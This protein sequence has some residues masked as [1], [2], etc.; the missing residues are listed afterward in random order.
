MT[1]SDT[2][3]AGPTTPPSQIPP[4]R[5][6]ELA[7]IVIYGLLLALVLPEHEPWTDEAQSWL[8][9]RDSS[10][11]GLLTERLRYEGTP[12]LWTLLL[13]VPAKLGLPYESMQVIGALG[14][15]GAVILLV[16]FSP[17][18]LWLR[19]LLPFTYFLGYQYALVARNYCLLALLLFALVLA[20]R[21]RAQR[22]GPFAWCLGLLSH[23]TLHST[24]LAGAIWLVETA[25]ALSLARRDG[26]A[27]ARPRLTALF[28]L[29]LNFVLVL[30]IIWPPADLLLRPPYNDLAVTLGILDITTAEAVARPLWLGLLVL[31]LLL[32]MFQRGRVLA[33]F[34]LGAGFVYALLGLRY[35][36]FWHTGTLSVFL[37]AVAW[38]AFDGAPEAKWPRW[39]ALGALT[40]YAAVQIP[41]TF[42]AGWNDFQRPY[43]ASREAASYLRN[44]GLDRRVVHGMDVHSVAVLPYFEQN[45]LANFRARSP[46]SYWIWN[47]AALE[48][49]RRERVLAGRPEFLLV[50]GKRTRAMLGDPTSEGY[51]VERVFRGDIFWRAAR[52][53]TDDL[54]LY[55]R[56]DLKE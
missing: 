1:S 6:V 44:R 24:L 40:I 42:Q 13:S 2:P 29:G 22:Y 30:A 3:A 50:T 18:P 12:A 35:F 48:G 55:R 20:A 56:S 10:L 16:R 39:L 36:A 21:Q 53:E 47:Q 54:I 15:F 5:L 33:V 43:S 9:A 31:A 7:V 37:V 19:A 26:L 17:F 45:F 52:F 23:V 32:P 46:G 4:Q 25:S 49:M 41:G 14:A 8:L 34:L 27:A 51:V 11:W 28:L 38:W